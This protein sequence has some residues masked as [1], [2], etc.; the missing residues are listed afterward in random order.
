VTVLKHKWIIPVAATVL[1][2]GAGLYLWKSLQNDDLP[3]GL[4]VGN[5]RIEGTEVKVAAKYPGRIV[6]ITPEEGDDVKKD[7]TIVR[8]DNR[9]MLAKL[10]EVRAEH[11]RVNSLH[12]AVHLNNNWIAIV[13]LCG[14]RQRCWMPLKA[15]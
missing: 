9:E 12:V 7:E 6:E 11:Q 1:L 15:S 2:I 10:A 4:F 8:L 5:G 3:K 13:L 14:L